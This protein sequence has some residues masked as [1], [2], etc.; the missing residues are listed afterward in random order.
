VKQCELCGKEVD[1]FQRKYKGKGYCSNCYAYL[2]KKNKCIQCG[3]IKRIYCYLE[4]PICEQCELKNKPCIRC[5]KI[6]YSLGKITES[7]PVC[8][9]CSKY[10]RSKIA[11]CIC[12]EKSF[13]VARRL[14]YGENEPICEKCFN[15]KHFVSCSRCKQRVAPFLFDFKHNAFCKPCATKPDKACVACNVS[16]PAGHHSK[17]CRDCHA[18]IRIEMILKTQKV[19]LQL[20]THELYKN[21]SVWLVNRRD[22]PVASRQIVRDIEIFKFL[23]NWM[24]QNSKWPSYDEYALA[25]TVRKTRKHLLATTFLNEYGIFTISERTKSEIGD[26]NTISRLLGK[27]PNNST[28]KTYLNGY[29]EEMLSRYNLGKTSA[30]SLRL[31]ITPVVAMLA[32]GL[33]Q[34]KNTPDTELIK[35][36][37][38]LHYGQRAA[39]TGFINFLK[40]RENTDIS[41]PSKHSFVF[42]RPLKSKTRLRQ[43]IIDKLRSNNFEQDN[44]LKIAIEY[45]HNIRFPMELNKIKAL[46]VKIDNNWYRLSLA[47]KKLLIP[48]KVHL[49]RT[50]TNNS[51]E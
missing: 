2:F 24:N 14:R 10:F 5:K 25:L 7:G 21:Y 23:E 4:A 49:N 16:L 17:T 39:L 48:N 28:L 43:E 41:L 13:S 33:Q 1:N 44:Y 35:Q 45:F 34:G 12:E 47:G 3:E 36:Y 22:A 31:A 37:L 19:N 8:N 18:K 15:I 20:Q 42:N 50:A 27:I 51:K 40:R 6:K 30:R 9:S 46:P 29:Y 32:L 11:C 26:L 38:W